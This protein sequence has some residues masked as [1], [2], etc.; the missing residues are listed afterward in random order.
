MDITST[1]SYIS[2]EI[3]LLS[4]WKWKNTIHTESHPLLAIHNMGHSY[5]AHLSDAYSPLH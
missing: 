3:S 5:P 4:L 1:G 2:R